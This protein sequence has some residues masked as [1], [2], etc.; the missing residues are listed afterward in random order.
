QRSPEL[1]QD[2]LQQVALLIVA[3]GVHATDPAQACVVLAH[4]RQ[5]LQLAVSGHGSWSVS[6]SS[7]WL[8]AGTRQSLQTG[9]LHLGEASRPRVNGAPVGAGP[10][11]L[12][13]PEPG[14]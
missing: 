3:T 10:G 4:Q 1:E 6:G 9:R 5:E 11:H 2:L 12:Q 13:C 8:V 14:P 7:V